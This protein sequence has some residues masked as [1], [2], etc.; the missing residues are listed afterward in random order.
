MG[1]FKKYI[2]S[3]GERGGT[4]KSNKNIQ[5]EQVVHPRGYVCL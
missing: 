4:S 5:R 1:P 2:L 3:E